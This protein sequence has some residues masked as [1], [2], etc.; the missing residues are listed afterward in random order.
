MPKIGKK[1][2]NPKNVKVR[3]DPYSSPMML[4]IIF[5]GK[6]GPKTRE[7]SH[8]WRG[9]VKIG[10]KT[11]KMRYFFR[12]S[13]NFF[14]FWPK[15]L[16]YMY[17]KGF[18][19]IFASYEQIGSKVVWGKCAMLISSFSEWPIGTRAATVWEPTE[20]TQNFCVSQSEASMKKFQPIISQDQ[21]LAASAGP[22]A[23][24]YPS[25]VKLT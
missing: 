12:P 1:C 3:I 11:Q 25:I 19:I 14:V 17:T 7:N 22:A 15:W 2:K 13:V 23:S 21:R 4:M 10:E 24:Q 5:D 6:N 18:W 16:V 20:K 8:I 9:W